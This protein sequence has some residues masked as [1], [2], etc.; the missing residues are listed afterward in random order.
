MVE[1]IDKSS[2]VE[3]IVEKVKATTRAK[4]FLF[5]KFQNQIIKNSL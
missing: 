5:K 2:S 1:D 3:G 4:L